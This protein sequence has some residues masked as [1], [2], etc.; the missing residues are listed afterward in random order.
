MKLKTLC[1]ILSVALSILVLVAALLYFLGNPV[2][3]VQDSLSGVESESVSQLEEAGY[4]EVNV[5]YEDGSAEAVISESKLNSEA[6]LEKYVGR[7]MTF[8]AVVKATSNAV[9]YIDLTPEAAELNGETLACNVADG[10]DQDL[11]A[12]VNACTPGDRVTVS[13]TFQKDENN[14]L[15]FYIASTKL[16]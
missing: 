4:T 5:T 8:T 9:G 7:S 16:A 12:V 6:A 14:Q 1:I 15:R 13:G 11:M 10:T 3:L 2:Q